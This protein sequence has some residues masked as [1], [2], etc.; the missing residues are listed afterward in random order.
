MQKYNILTK[1]MFY[2]IKTVFHFVK[3]VKKYTKPS[4][5]LTTEVFDCLSVIYRIL[6]SY[7]CVYVYFSQ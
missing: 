2:N 7:K 3:I 6:I 5:V 4:I 1:N